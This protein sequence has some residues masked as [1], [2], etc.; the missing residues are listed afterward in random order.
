MV[1]KYDQFKAGWDDYHADG[2]ARTANRMFYE[3]RRRDSNDQF[4]R[5]SNCAM[6]VLANH[7][8]SSL[9]AGLS[10][11]NANKK[12]QLGFGFE[13]KRTALAWT[14]CATLRVNW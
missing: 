5:A 2:P 14:N 4:K 1:G 12:I 11:H 3:G 10:I 13:P 7:V 6:L 9:E 8:I